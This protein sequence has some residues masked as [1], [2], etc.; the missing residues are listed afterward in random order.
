MGRGRPRQFD[1]EAVLE[2]AVQVFWDRGFGDA[3]L[4]EVM[5]R[6]G[7]GRQ[8]L[9]DSFGTKQELFVAALDR[10]R[11]QVVEAWRSRLESSPSPLAG[12]RAFLA[13]WNE[14]DHPSHGRGCL[15]VNTSCEVD[16]AEP[17]VHRALRR[18][19][20]AQDKLLRDA[21]ARAVEAGELPDDVDPAAWAA[22][23]RASFAGAAALARHGNGRAL[24]RTVIGR[25]AEELD[26]AARR[27]SG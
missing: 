12:L 6:A 19:T 13:A 8:S 7:I 21:F 3:A 18:H 22:Q 24:V 26:R 15:M 1:P 25:L 20:Q 16:A 14:R 27:V 11:E 17:E 9:Y 5:E 2:A 4:S 23:W 10:Y